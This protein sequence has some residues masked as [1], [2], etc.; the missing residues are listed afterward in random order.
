MIGPS[1]RRPDAHAKDLGVGRVDADLDEVQEHRCDTP[2]GAH[3]NVF[4]VPAGDLV[5]VQEAVPSGRRQA[6]MSRPISSTAEA[7]SGA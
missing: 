5:A 7:A 1:G 4:A 3:E 2:V 6:A